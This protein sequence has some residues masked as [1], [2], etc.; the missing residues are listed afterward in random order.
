MTAADARPK[1]RNPGQA[2]RGVA[3]RAILSATVKPNQPVPLSEVQA[4]VRLSRQRILGHLAQMQEGQ[5]IRGYSTA[6]GFVRVW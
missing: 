1:P 5:R 6:S 4:L 2:A 3:V